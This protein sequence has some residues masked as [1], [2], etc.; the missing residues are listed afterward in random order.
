MTAGAAQGPPA[1]FNA[2]VWLPPGDERRGYAESGPWYRESGQRTRQEQLIIDRLR[3]SLDWAQRR[4][5]PELEAIVGHRLF[6]GVVIADL[7]N[8]RLRH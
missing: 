8:G 1:A 3:R 2:R 7:Q 6:L 5:L 4:E